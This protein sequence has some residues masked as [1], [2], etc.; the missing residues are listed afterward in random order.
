MTTSVLLAL[1][2]LA[3][4][5]AAE[6]AALVSALV[7][8]RRQRRRAERLERELDER[9]ERDLAR[10][11]RRPLLAPPRVP[12]PQEA[13]RA[14]WETA[15]LVREKG[16]GGA[17]RSSV[18]DL[19]GW[20]QVERPDLARLAAGDGSVAILFSD[21]EGSTALNEELGD[22]AWVKVLARHDAV[23]RRC[24]EEHDGHVVKTQGD[25]FMVAFGPATDAVACAVDVQRALAGRRRRPL[26]PDVRVRIGIHRGEAVQR[27]NDLFG[28]NVAYAARVAGLAQGGE[29]LVS[30]AVLAA[31]PGLEVAE[32]REA[33]LKGLAGLHVVHLVPWEP[34]TDP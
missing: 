28:R 34:V 24:V 33:E 31:A 30:D 25:G 17:L 8:L 29:V 27:D 4:V 11:R 23:V 16:V 20:A 1:A 14:V 9:I 12:T 5:A 22:R 7:L 13:V 19:A 15:A 10:G 2:G 6:A 21:I 26:D 32:A 18:E 3:L